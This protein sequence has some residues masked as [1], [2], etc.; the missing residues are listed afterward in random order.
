MHTAK[1]SDGELALT[2]SCSQSKYTSAFSAFL[3]AQ[4][5]RDRVPW[6]A[7]HA[8]E[9]GEIESCSFQD[10]GEGR[11]HLCVGGSTKLFFK[12]AKRWGM[13]P[14]GHVAQT[15]EPLDSPTFSAGL[16]LAQHLNRESL[17]IPIY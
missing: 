3:Q 6:P 9:R 11:G 5:Q 15:Q 13:R 7:G 4:I 17:V 2:R 12:D 8:L 14:P 16:P 10:P 1:N